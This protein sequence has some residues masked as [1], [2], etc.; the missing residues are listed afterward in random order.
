[1][2]KQTINVGITA[3]DRRG[4]PL[5][6][7]FTKIN[8][9]FDEVYD[10]IPTQLSDLAND[11]G[12]ITLDAVPTQVSD[13]TND[14]GYITANSLPTQLSDLTDDI[15]FATL[16]VVPTQLSDLSNDEGFITNETTHVTLTQR[17]QLG[18][19]V[20]FSNQA[21]TS[22][23]DE[24]GPGLIIARSPGGG[25][26]YNAASESEYDQVSR[27]SPAGTLWNY[28]GNGFGNLDTIKNRYYTTFSEALKHQVG[29]NIIGSDLVMHDTINDKYYKFEFSHWGIQAAGTFAYT[30]T[31]IIPVSVGVEFPDGTYQ[32]TAW[33][34]FLDRYNKI[35]V[36]PFSGHELAAHEAGSVIYFFNT[37]VTLPNNIENDCV[38]GSFYTLVVGN[39]AASLRV[40]KYSNANLIPSIESAITPIT[41]VGP[42]NDTEYPLEPYS[43][44]H[45]IKIERNKWSLVP[46][47]YQTF[48]IGSVFGAN[49]TLLVDG[50][51]ETIPYSVLSD[52]PT[53]LSEFSND[54]DYAVIVGTEIVN[55]GLPADITATGDISISGILKI[56]TSVHE[57]FQI[58]ENATGVI[59]H[60]CS[61]GHIF[62]H[63]TPS[64]NWTVNLTNLDLA[65]TYATSVTL[66]ITQ[67]STG[68][69]PSALQIGGVAQTISWQG[70][71][72]PTPGTN[73]V[74]VVSFSILNNSGTYTVLGQLTD[75]GNAT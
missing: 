19:P 25:G 43:I 2:A 51:N 18:E 38:I 47:G 5:R 12:F 61:L 52:A 67:G 41:N 27:V 4:D 28:E 74:D 73:G 35:H 3:N 48:L 64:A 7:A 69:Y 1:M 11:E 56:D 13:L 9:N 34:G 17:Y 16:D 24:I 14:A 33:T 46:A 57:K 42:F 58:K 10:I 60:D 65:S 39:E 26:I 72:V 29:R 63:T 22:L 6:V 21:N 66:V 32:P 54:L 62:A 44:A 23:T 59:E 40:K 55:N 70:G 15:G 37:H 50:D 31:E 49:N 36:G 68:Y 71:T 20:F 75:F 53:A 45:L 8:Q 30:R